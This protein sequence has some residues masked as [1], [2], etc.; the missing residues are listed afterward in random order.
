MS[1]AHFLACLYKVASSSNQKLHHTAVPLN[2]HRIIAA[3]MIIITL[4]CHDD[5]LTA[6]YLF[7]T[8]IHT[9]GW[10]TTFVTISTAASTSTTFTRDLGTTYFFLTFTSH[11]LSLSFS[12]LSR[13]LLWWHIVPVNCYYFSFSHSC[14]FS[15]FSAS[16]RL[17]SEVDF[18]EER[19]YFRLIQA[20]IWVNTTTFF[21]NLRSLL[22]ALRSEISVWCVYQLFYLIS[23][24]PMF[25]VIIPSV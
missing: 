20:F 17:D 22:T 23:Y 19:Q 6:A 3:I 1:Y 4:T 2:H 8:P 12:L 16:C 24:F 13:P 9:A 7:F 25:S 14:L 11:F 18:V 15:L 5:Y 21:Y 10:D